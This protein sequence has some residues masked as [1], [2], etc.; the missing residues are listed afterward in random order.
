MPANPQI[1]LARSA[2]KCIRRS[3]LVP[4]KASTA[5]VLNTLLQRQHLVIAFR[6]GDGGNSKPFA[7]CI[8][9]S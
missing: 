9:V 4:L 6:K 7:G 2:R 3:S 1:G 5:S 8:F